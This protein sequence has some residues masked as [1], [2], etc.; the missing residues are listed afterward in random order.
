MGKTNAMISFHISPI[1][2]RKQ[3]SNILEIDENVKLKFHFTFY[4]F[5]WKKGSN[6]LEIENIVNQRF[7]ITFHHF[8]GNKRLKYSRNGQ[9]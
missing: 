8:T 9:Y 3:V 5:T 7:H 2:Y 1:F 4:H 6:F